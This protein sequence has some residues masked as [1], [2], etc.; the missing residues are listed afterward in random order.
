M[1]ETI[2]ERV[3]TDEQIAA[4]DRDGFLILKG[5]LSRSEAE[6][7]RRAI[8]D[9]IPRD[10]NFEDP[11]FVNAGR[12][13]PYHEGYGEQETRRGHE[14]N[15]IMDDPVFIPLLCNAY[16]Y[17]VA[18]DLMGEHRLRVED[19]TIGVTI[20][21]DEG[22]T[23][24]QPIHIDASVP[25]EIP[26]FLFT[27]EEMHVG[28]LFYLT[29]VETNG[30]GIHVIPGGHKLVEAEARSH[31]EGRHLHAD[32]LDI[33]GYPDTVEVTGEAGDYIMTHPMLPHAASQNRRGRARVAYFT[34]YARIDNPH[35]P[36]PAAGPFRFN[37]RQLKAMSSLGRK[38][39]GVD[40]W[41]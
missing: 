14:D 31:P 10:L 28:G 6:H 21:N 38:L 22:P 23:L 32:W 40:P 35:Y 24:S 30:G 11:W 15:G 27:P 12:I 8:L 13:K 36:P 37:T 17:R 26:N 41:D 5:V 18:A 29:D 20:R 9:M 1:S 25:P 16:V 3:L 7:Y 39:L 33:Q 34:R 2:A 19:G 4:F